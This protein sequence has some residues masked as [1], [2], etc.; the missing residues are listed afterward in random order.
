MNERLPE[1][2]ARRELR[3]SVA[4]LHRQ[5]PHPG[6][7]L[8]C[9]LLLLRQPQRRRAPERDVQVQ[10]RIA[11]R[12]RQRGELGEPF[13]PVTRPAQHRERVV[14]RREQA[15]ALLRRGRLRQRDL[16]HTQDLVGRVRGE[17]G[18]RRLDREAHA[19]LRVAGRPSVMGEE[20][21]RLGRRFPGQ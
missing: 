17:R 15:E 6:G 18:R 19:D 21:Q 7:E 2:H 9:P 20:R 14:A 10:V 1:L 4:S 13:Q 5:G 16:H 11:E 3:G 8:R 12:F